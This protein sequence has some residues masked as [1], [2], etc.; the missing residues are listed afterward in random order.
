ME[1]LAGLASL[2]FAL[3]C[4]GAFWQAVV[5][6]APG[7]WRL[8]F[9]LLLLLVGLHGLL[10]GCV[11]NRW[12]AK[13]LL[14]VLFVATAFAAHYTKAYGIY[15]D[16]D[17]LRN[18][19]QT[20]WPEAR[21]LLTP[22]LSWPLF[23]LAVVPLALLWKVRI[24]RRDWRSAVVRRIALLSLM[25]LLLLAGGL[26]AGKD[27]AALMRNHRE[28]R[29]L[30]TP[31][32]YLY[33]LAR[34]AFAQPPGSK[35]ALLP[36]GEDAVQAPR[37]P[38][39]RPRLLLLVVG[40]TARA[41]NWG[42]NGYARQTT[43]ELARRGDMVNFTQMHACGSSTEV[44]LPCMFSPFGRH[45]YDEKKIRAH[46]SLLHV[47]DRAGVATLWR[48]NQS[49]C[50]GV[51][52]GLP[53]E[54]L[55]TAA[56][57]R[58]CSGDRC[59]DEIL[60]QG[61]VR[62]LDPADGDRIIVLHQ[63]GNHGPSYYDRYPPQ[64]RRFTPTCDTGELSRCTQQQIVGSYDNTLLYTDHVLARAIDFL[65]T[66]ASGYDTALIYLS[67]HGE[68]LGE[69]GLYLHGVPYAIA[70][71]QQLRVPMTMWFSSGFAADAKLDLSCLR[72]RAALPADHDNLFPS[73][74]GLFDVRTV[75]YDR[76]RDLF[77]NCRTLP[78]ARLV[79]VQGMH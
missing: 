74:L 64:F 22:D 48:D 77:A 5:A 66:Q 56:D 29:Y 18:V 9:A 63:L 10:L 30:V 11:L 76:Q 61:L 45:D 27:I 3:C 73:V 23:A 20:D 6:H 68:S 75:A 15:L 49:G 53:I 38:G 16:P 55:S 69:K 42:L 8:W 65:Q 17:M 46:Q 26:L 4:N 24:A 34:V 37:A 35:P 60:L 32:N 52:D 47:L 39:A 36:V 67:D 14:A 70:P 57:P 21:E 33:S 1:A 50:K 58:F 40:E 72:Q 2:F 31:A 59:L 44:S 25:A 51:C 13:P 54:R 19:L 62:K 28:D 12:T 78:D 79:T 41:Q 43:P 71:E 7:Q